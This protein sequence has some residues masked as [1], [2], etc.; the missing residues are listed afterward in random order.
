M[1]EGW[2]LTL[3]FLSWP[4]WYGGWNKK[5]E[6][7]EEEV[8]EEE[9][10]MEEM[11]EMEEEEVEQ[12]GFMCRWFIVRRPRKSW[13]IERRLRGGGKPTQLYCRLS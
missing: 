12:E 8:E 9:E 2:G 1:R 6:G 5:E 4:M 7:R 10:K 3:C 11:E 13:C